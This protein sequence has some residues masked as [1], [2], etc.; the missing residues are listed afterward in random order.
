MATS[1]EK[2]AAVGGVVKR[3]PRSVFLID[4]PTLANTA[5]EHMDLVLLPHPK[6]GALARFLVIG[7]SILEVQSVACD[8]SSWFIG[9][10]V[11]ADGTLYAATRIDA[12]FL[13][14]PL[15]QTSRN[16]SA[17]HEGYF[18]EPSQI[19]NSKSFP[20]SVSIPDH[21]WQK[22]CDK[23]DGWDGPVYRLND[24]KLTQ[25]L[26]YKVEKVAQS[27]F[28]NQMQR[29]SKVDQAA[30][31]F[32]RLPLATRKCSLGLISEYLSQSNFENLLTTYNFNYSDIYE[33]KSSKPSSSSFN[34]VLITG[35]SD[36]TKMP[37]LD[38]QGVKR[39]KEA[40]APKSK[41]L[42]KVDTK[43][44]KSIMSFFGKKP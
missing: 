9:N 2:K 18:V 21:Q 22:I 23:K 31:E 40:A 15:L 16:K 10:S 42:A 6:Y 41:K 28:E 20:S 39:K 13:A 33:K 34:G 30:P 4:D 1:A 25:W 38:N 44:M 11:E 5:C 17:E 7:Q 36:L 43:G 27:L 26:R 32:D 3:A 37:G 35:D 8:P 12:L 19:L 24:D 14:L 29:E